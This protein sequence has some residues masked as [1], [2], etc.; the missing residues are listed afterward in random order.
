MIARLLASTSAALA[1][2]ACGKPPGLP[3]T[4]NGCDA[5]TSG[6]KAN[7]RNDADRPVKGVRISADFYSKF[8]FARTEGTATIPGGLNPGDNKDV[9]F[10][11]D[12]SAVTA[13]GKASRCVATHIDFLDGTSA[14]LP[15]GAR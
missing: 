12:A 6:I 14:D 11:Y 7:L 10:S 9:V 2:C 15:A 3:V 8:R 13:S 4:L 1:L 5:G